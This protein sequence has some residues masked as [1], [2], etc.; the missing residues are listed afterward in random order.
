MMQKITSGDPAVF[1]IESGVVQFFKNPGQ[2]ALGYFVIFV[3]GEQYG[4]RTENATLLACSFDAVERRINNR[5]KHAF[6]YTHNPVECIVESVRA[7]LYVD[8][9]QEDIFFGTSS[10]EELK[11]DLALHEIVWAPDGDAAFDDGGHVLQ[12]DFNNKVHIIAFKNLVNEKDVFLTI[13][14]VILDAPH[15]Y[16]V[17]EDW[18]TKFESEWILFTKNSSP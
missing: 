10:A 6:A 7:A 9:R 11:E 18:K 4:V 15:F 1:A 14:S 5:G 16:E 17:L 2:R 12:F 3:K 8:E 13:K